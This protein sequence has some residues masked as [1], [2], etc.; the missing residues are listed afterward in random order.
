[1]VDMAKKENLYRFPRPM[2]T[3][4]LA[5]QYQQN[6]SKETQEALYNYIIHNWILS[7]GKFGSVPMDINTLARTL[8]I[9]IE[10]IQLY[11]RDHILTSKIWQPEIQQDL[12]N[13]LL[14]QQL[15]WALED[16]MEVMQQVDILKASQNGHYTPFISAELNKALKLRLETSTSLQQVI[17]TLTGGGGNVNIFNLN[18]QNNVQQNNYISREEAMEL[19][20]EN[21]G[22]LEDKSDQAKYLEQAYDLKQLPTVVANDGMENDGSTFNVNRQELNEIT[23]DYKGAIEMSSKERH[24]M[25]REIE[26]RIDPDEEDPEFDSYEEE[27]V[28]IPDPEPVSIAES[29]LT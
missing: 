25:R 17:R 15:A 26:M 28:D 1:M 14:G 7:N 4:A 10:Y 20:T 22:Y 12:I 24:A 29:Y 8:G 16:R 19:I 6:K 21:A 9:T 11:M 18:Q 2:G 5:I 13:G 3:T 23:D 27:D